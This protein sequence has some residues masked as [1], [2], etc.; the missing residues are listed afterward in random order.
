MEPV[1]LA[2]GTALTGNQRKWCSNACS[3]RAASNMRNDRPLAFAKWRK[4]AKCQL[5]GK[6]IEHR[7]PQAKFCSVRC[8]LDNDH[9]KQRERQQAAKRLAGKPVRGD[10]VIC[11]NAHCSRTAVFSQGRSWCSSKC[12]NYVSYFRKKFGVEPGG[13]CGLSESVYFRP[14][15]E[16]GNLVASRVSTGHKL[17]LPCRKIRNRAAN[18]IKNH[19]RRTRG[20]NAISVDQLAQR[21]GSRCNLCGRK[22]DMNLS[23]RAKW[24][25]T[26]DHLVPVIDG[27]T[28]DPSNLALAHRFCNV[29]RHSRGPVQMLLAS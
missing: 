2:C 19:R 21:D 28:N 18:A 6:V 4:S 29:S 24:G 10:L 8:K 17:C 11:A 16:C 22:I 12:Q 1:C 13:I 23:G 14:C 26:I 5:C 15:P 7:G 20:R 3:S 27:G 25:P 9:G